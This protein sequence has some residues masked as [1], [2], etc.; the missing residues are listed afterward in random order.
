[1]R[2]HLDAMRARLAPLGRQVYFVDAPTSTAGDGTVVV[3]EAPYFV[4]WTSAGDPSQERSVVGET[5]SHDSLVNLTSVAA[6]PEDVLLVQE[7]AREALCP[8][9]RPTA[10]APGAVLTLFSAEQVRVDRDVVAPPLHRHPAYGVDV[11]R[12]ISTPA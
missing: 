7:R 5:D 9:A 1:M 6:T 11:Y 4:L 2:A 3:P 12:L 8:G 10:L